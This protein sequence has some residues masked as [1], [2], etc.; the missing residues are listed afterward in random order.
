M[1]IQ[2]KFLSLLQQQQP[3][4][5][6][7]VAELKDLLNLSQR[8]IYTRLNKKVDFTLTESNL[9][10][11]HYGLKVQELYDTPQPSSGKLPHT[12]SEFYNTLL[13]GWV[14]QVE[15]LADKK[16]A[17]IHMITNSLPFSLAFR[18]PDLVKFRLH[19]M[20]KRHWQTEKTSHQLDLMNQEFD[21]VPDFCQRISKVYQ[22]FPTTEI[23]GRSTF[24]LTVDQLEL[25]YASGELSHNDLLY[26]LKEVDKL[27]KLSW[28]YAQS[29]N[30]KGKKRNDFLSTDP[31]YTLYLNKTMVVDEYTL[32]YWQQK[33]T[34]L[35]FMYHPVFGT[36]TS[37]E[38]QQEVEK[39]CRLLQ[40]EGTLL[41]AAN[42]NYRDAYFAGMRKLLASKRRKIRKIAS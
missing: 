30:K 39:Y 33:N 23:W 13:A 34:M 4:R 17:A 9:L 25:L 2:D 7:L 42:G 40:Q 29:G 27:V 37:F 41:S 26:L 8:A 36:I 22:Q 28:K 11:Q 12:R 19:L 32:L 14:E 16:K 6:Q 5:S 3:K 20:A 24:F 1:T 38:R 21:R 18:F 35:T 31:D 15:Q 10:V